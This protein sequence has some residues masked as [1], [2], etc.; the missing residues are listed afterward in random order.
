[1]LTRLD[2]ALQGDNGEQLTNIIRQQYPIALFDE[3]QD[4]DATQY[5]IISTLYPANANADLGCF[6]IGDPKQAIYSFR[7]ADIFTYLKAHQA[8]A[9]QHY[10]LETNYR[11][12]VGLVK[13]TNQVFHQADQQTEGA[14][15]FKRDNS[16]PLPF[17]PVNALGRKEEWMIDQQPAPALSAWH[18]ESHDPIGMPTYRETMAE[19]AASE[20]VRLLNKG[21][22]GTTGFKMQSGEIRSIQPSDIAILVRSGTEARAMRSA[23]AKRQLRSVYLSERDSIYA[24]REAADLLLWLK[25]IADPRNERKVRTAL[26]TATIGWPY[27]TLLQL[28]QDELAWEQQLERFLGYHQ[29]WQ[30]DGILP[31]VRQ[32]LND[33]ALH[34]RLSDDNSGERRLTNLLHL[35]ELLQQASTKL[36]GQQALLRHLAE[37][38]ASPNQANDENVIRLES[39]ANLIRVITIH[40]SK[41]L[42][43]PLVFLPFICSF[44]EVSARNGGF[45]R[46]HDADKN[47]RIDLDK[48]AENKTISDNERLQ[49]DI[50]LFYVAMTRPQ[51]ACWLG[52]APIKSGNAKDCQLEK[53]G[54]GYVLGWQT[55][56][57][58]TALGGQLAQLKGDCDGITIT[59]LPEPSTDL[60]FPI[61]QREQLGLPRTTAFKISDNWWIASYS[62]L[63]VEHTHPIQNKSLTNTREPETA[64]DDKRSDEADMAVDLSAKTLLDIHNLPRGAE[65]GVLV[66]ELLEECAYA[67]FKTVQSSPEL[68][69]QLISKIFS[70]RAWDNKRDIISTA[71]MQWLQMPLLEDSDA[72]LCDLDS[73]YYQAEMEFLLGADNVDVSALD[74]LVTQHTFVAKPRPHL[75]QAQMH[76]LLKGYIDLVFVY[77][78]K[79]YVADYKFN[80]LGDNDTA[81]NQETLEAALLDKR[82]DVQFALYLLALHRL[83][84]TRLG[85]AY[86]Y[87]THVGGALYLFLRGTNAET[88]GR[89]FVKPPWSLIDGLDRLFTGVSDHNHTVNGSLS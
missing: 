38:I 32:L 53:S 11:S 26:S 34:G 46:Y 60:Y 36:E 3:F 62:A 27:Q 73:G 77:G 43:Y 39:D 52:I 76:G 23:L 83:L 14:F 12:T 82:Y 25:A 54:M 47:L 13:A 65:P 56:M 6:M 71:L 75:L 17:L 40:K 42:E 22:Q 33:Y 7:G 29:R 10:T 31:A 24:T 68:R 59:S 45:Y 4:T 66:H 37:E 49:E 44:R 30:Q 86:D 87:D 72:S 28:T 88:K 51:Y 89:I 16:N 84:K 67:G 80:A 57:P 63:Q 41:G 5:R 48:L 2:E 74:R 50:R 85:A 21:Q 8:T 19:V 9:G 79:Y 69:E 18:W 58:A 70:H 55:K 78:Q 61:A 20:I 15:R 35:A 64:Q 81:Y 1:M